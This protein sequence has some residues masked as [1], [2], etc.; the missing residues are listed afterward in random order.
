MVDKRFVHD[1][2]YL[3]FC[4]KYLLYC[5]IIDSELKIIIIMNAIMKLINKLYHTIVTCSDSYRISSVNEV[6]CC[7]VPGE[8]FVTQSRALGRD[9]ASFCSLSG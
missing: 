1:Y 9:K 8:L 6:T 2:F 3:L 5:I 4:L 7:P